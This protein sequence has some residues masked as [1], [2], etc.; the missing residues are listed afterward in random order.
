MKLL[1]AP[2]TFKS[3]KEWKQYVWKIIIDGFVRSVSAQEI[4][5]TL[6][7]LLTTHEKEYVIK[8]AAAISF[9]EQGKSYRDIGEMLWLSPTTISAIRKSM[10]QKNGYVSRYTRRKN[11]G[12]KKETVAK[13]KEARP[14]LKLCF[15]ELFTI[16]P[17]PDLRK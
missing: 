8:R 4:E 15:E 3:R 2:S 6:D 1:S 11:E 16:P 13:K 17:P 12:D 10:V 7:M 5:R 9:F 14:S